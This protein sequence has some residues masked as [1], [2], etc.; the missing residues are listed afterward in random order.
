MNRPFT[1]VWRIRLK[2]PPAVHRR[3]TSDLPANASDPINLDAMT[4]AMPASCFRPRRTSTPHCAAYRACR[5]STHRPTLHRPVRGSMLPWFSQLSYTAIVVWPLC[6]PAEGST[7]QWHRRNFRIPSTT[8][9]SSAHL[10][11]RL[12][13]LDRFLGWMTALQ[14][15]FTRRFM[16][17]H[18]YAWQTIGPTFCSNSFFR[19]PFSK[20][21]GT[22]PN[23]S[24]FSAVRINN[25]FQNLRSP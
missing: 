8:T 19:T 10:S 16:A 20:V 11:H 22:A 1:V 23:F 17:A 5:R 25:G 12:Y 6:S 7:D 2:I 21:T 14:M 24:T 9:S 15:S 13:Q 4:T 18:A 3:L